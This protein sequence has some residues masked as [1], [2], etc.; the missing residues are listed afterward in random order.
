MHTHN[1]Y[2]TL[3]TTLLDDEESA[4]KLAEQLLESDDHPLTF[5][6]KHKDKHFANRGI[7]HAGNAEQTLC[8]M[9][10]I[11]S[12]RQ[13]VYELDWKADSEELNRALQL[14]S[15]GKIKE[16]IFTPEDEEDADGMYEL[17]DMAEEILKEYDFGLV[18]FPLESDSHPIALVPLGQQE[19]IQAMIN[20]L[21]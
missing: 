19:E 7:N 6:E 3:L 12:E 2:T 4:G 8:F 11:L 14:L 10:D 21:F 9:L 15:R 1:R 13:I 16:H 17:L 18:L 20:E 5:F